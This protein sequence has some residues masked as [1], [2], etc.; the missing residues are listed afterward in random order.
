MEPEKINLIKIGYNKEENKYFAT[1]N[2]LGLDKNE[3]EKVIKYIQISGNKRD[4]KPYIND[5]D[6]YITDFFEAELFESMYPTW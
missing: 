3:I 2:V 1:F 5:N 4:C 6:F